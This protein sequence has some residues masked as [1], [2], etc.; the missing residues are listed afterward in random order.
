MDQR[1]AWRGWVR[2]RRP[3]IAS[4]APVHPAACSWALGLRLLAAQVMA[5]VM[6][7]LG[8]GRWAGTALEG[9]AADPP[10]DVLQRC[11]QQC[12]CIL[13]RYPEPPTGAV[14]PATAHGA[15]SHL[16]SAVVAWVITAQRGHRCVG[17]L[18]QHVRML[19]LCRER[20]TTTSKYGQCSRLHQVGEVVH[21]K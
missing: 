8:K 7:L 13:S 9:A 1:W 4:F 11:W 21:V 16:T 3:H 5:D 20:D 10:H 14:R 12:L 19:L 15:S 2:R 17:L 6:F 18:A